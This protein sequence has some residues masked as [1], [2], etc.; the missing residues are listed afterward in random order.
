MNKI[1]QDLD[2][3]D[4]RVMGELNGGHSHVNDDSERLTGSRAAQSS[5]GGV[6][7]AGTTA[8]QMKVGPLPK[9]EMDLM[10][11]QELAKLVY[12]LFLGSNNLR[13]I[14]FSGVQAGVG[15]SW[16]VARLAQLV[17]EADAGSVCIVDTDLRDPVLHKYFSVSNGPG[18]SDALVDTRPIGEFVKH[19]DGPLHLLTGGS[20]IS[21][22]DPLLSSSTFR[23]R[24]DELRASFDFLL[25]DT[26]PLGESA[27]ALLVGRKTD[28]LTLIVEAN[29]TNREAA[30]KTVRDAATANVRVLGTV[31]NKRTFPIP[32][33]IYKRL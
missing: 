32:E 19:F 1:F 15:C 7:V 17:A 16:I 2:I 20:A 12:R 28:G 9:L 18:L 29:S 26:P 6:A 10:T 3:P 5:F 4:R 30:L 31:L 25:F 24:M 14:A 13:A 11:R 21:K 8:T 27:D 23:L 33:A 22:G